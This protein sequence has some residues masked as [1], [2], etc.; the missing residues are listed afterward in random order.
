MPFDLLTVLVL[1]IV[2]VLAGV[3]AVLVGGTM[4]FTIPLMQ[5]LFPQ[6]SFGAIVGNIKVGSLTRGIGSTWTT[7]KQLLPREV[8]RL[9]ALSFVGTVAGAN[10]IAD[11][12]QLWLF[13]AVIGSVV[14]AVLSPRLTTCIGP[15]TFDFAAVLTGFYAGL[16]GAGVGIMLLGLLRVRYPGDTQ[17]GLAKIQSTAIE[18]M[19]VIVAV[20]VH[21]AHGNLIMAIWLPWSVGSL[22]GGLVGGA[23]LVRLGKLS[24]RLQKTLLYSSFVFAVTVAGFKFV[25]QL[26]G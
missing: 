22:I 24:G 6:A 1:L 19:L 9:A 21:F 10:L 14:I 12:S 20:G 13:P 4:F 16:F 2:G 5:L 26:S 23:L 8:T 15:R 11:L 7:R 17:I 3:I 25:Q 18:F